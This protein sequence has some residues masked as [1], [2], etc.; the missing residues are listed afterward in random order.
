MTD[1]PDFLSYVPEIRRCRDTYEG[2]YGGTVRSGSHCE[3][4]WR[5]RKPWVY[6]LLPQTINH[7]RPGSTRMGELAEL[8]T[9]PRFQKPVEGT[10]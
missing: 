6:L 3:A 7:N 10:T 8:R 9:Q 4:R 2:R 1:R 5:P